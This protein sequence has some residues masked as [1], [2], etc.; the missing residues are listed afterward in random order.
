LV[1]LSAARDPDG[2]ESF[3]FS[4]QITRCRP[5]RGSETADVVDADV[6]LRPLYAPH[7]RPVEP[8]ALGE[9]LLRPAMSLAKR[10]DVSANDRSAVDE[11]GRE[12]FLQWWSPTS[13][14]DDDA[15]MMPLHLETL[16]R[17][18]DTMAIRLRWAL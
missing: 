12:G 16:S 5:E 3:R 9:N 8:G 17:I 11:R 4:Q 1:G 13:H 14:G 18:S 7:I 10:S 6:P 15:R 2:A